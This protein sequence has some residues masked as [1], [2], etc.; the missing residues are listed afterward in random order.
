MFVS[1]KEVATLNKVAN[2]DYASVCD[3]EEFREMLSLHGRWSNVERACERAP[4]SAF[5]RKDDNYSRRD[6]NIYIF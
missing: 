5:P 3:R 4:H 1:L 2:S 6:D